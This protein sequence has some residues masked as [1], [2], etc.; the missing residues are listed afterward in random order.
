[1]SAQG[2]WRAVLDT[3][4]NKVY[5]YNKATKET[6]W[7]LPDDELP[8]VIPLSPEQQ[9]IYEKANGKQSGNE[10]GSDD[11]GGHN[12]ADT[13]EDDAKPAEDDHDSEH[14]KRDVKELIIPEDSNKM[15]VSPRAVAPLAASASPPAPLQRS[16]SVV[17]NF[18]NPVVGEDKVIMQAKK[19]ARGRAML[20]GDDEDAVNAAPLPS[21]EMR[22]NI[23]SRLEEDEADLGD[24]LDWKKEIDR[25]NGRVYYWNKKNLQTS[26]RRPKGWLD[27]VANK[28]GPQRQEEEKEE[29]QEVEISKAPMNPNERRMMMARAASVSR[30]KGHKSS[31]SGDMTPKSLKSSPSADV[32]DKDDKDDI[33]DSRD[34]SGDDDDE[35]E[36]EMRPDGI[37]FELTH[38]RKGLINRIFH[39]GKSNDRQTLLSFKKSV[40]K[41]SLLKENR[42]KDAVC[43]QCFKNILAYMGDR[44]S[45]KAEIFHAK[46]LISTALA[47]GQSLKDELYLQVCK[48]V[49]GHPR[50]AHCA[51]G[52]ELM[53]LFLGCFPPSNVMRSY[54][55]AMI[56]QALKDTDTDDSLKGLM[57]TV[58]ERLPKIIDLGPRVEAPS[59]FELK[60]DQDGTPYSLKVYTLDGAVKTLEADCF[61]LA[62]DANRMMVQQLSIGY[63]QI[64]AIFE[65]NRHGDERVL[66]EKIRVLDVIGSWERIIKEN[67][68]KHPEPFKLLFK[69]DL[70]LKSTNPRVCEDDETLR[71]LYVQSFHDIVHEKYPI[72]PKI[73]PSMVSL[74]LITAY[75]QYEQS[76]HTLEWLE[77]KCADMFPPAVL[78]YYSKKKA[79]AIKQAAQKVLA[80]YSKLEGVTSGEARL[81]YLDYAQDWPLYGAF[82]AQ[83]EQDHN[84]DLPPMI[85]IAVNCD[86]VSLVHPKTKDVIENFGWNEIVTWGSSSSRFTIQV[87]DLISQRKLFFKTNQGNELARLVQGYVSEYA[88]L[89]NG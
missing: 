60:R 48:Q 57:N 66:D 44:K 45:V 68:I 40:I 33:E 58:L 71:M 21:E 76:V 78:N 1:M 24:P 43:I 42:S 3:K 29:K 75:G 32:D 46:K 25:R 80:K 13:D 15:T 27:E 65:V 4:T 35:P 55:E 5:Y 85:R 54:I 59:E 64:F 62:R 56:A 72:D 39:L 10:S 38:H 16:G 89:K 14:E 23:D 73:A 36:L 67:N 83:A 47:H 7:K 52:W 20:D 12:P 79:E 51:K 2:P 86:G 8:N 17:S 77:E 87:G 11:D 37:K 50:L 41:K 34:K 28:S 61:T 81:S 74:H 19:K 18:S 49:T 26:Y 82:T 70:V 31:G 6:K 53:V 69:I 9:A 63:P 84:K 30:L 88:A 22:S